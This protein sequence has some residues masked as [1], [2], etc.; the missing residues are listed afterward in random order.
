MTKKLKNNK[1]R[2]NEYYDMQN[3][4]DELY[5]KSKNGGKFINLMHY[6]TCENN[7]KLAYRN[8]KK[9]RKEEAFRSWMFQ[10]LSELKQMSLCRL[11]SV[12]LKIIS[13][14]Q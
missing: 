9:L 4:Y 2:H 13:R 14:K 5:Q 8:I 12:N 10:I 3:I 6:I 1:L 7:I 11:S